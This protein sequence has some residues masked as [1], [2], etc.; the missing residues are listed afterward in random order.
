MTFLPSQNI[1]EPYSEL[2]VIKPDK[3]M[4]DFNDVLKKESPQEVRDILTRDHV[5]KTRSVLPPQRMKKRS[6]EEE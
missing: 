4:Q 1:G 3:L 6:R 5:G 2:A